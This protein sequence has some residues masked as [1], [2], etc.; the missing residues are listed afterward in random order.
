MMI[1]RFRWKSDI[2]RQI[3]DSLG[4]ENVPPG[5]RYGHF[6]LYCHGLGL[7]DLLFSRK[8]LEMIPSPQKLRTYSGYDFSY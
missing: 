7:F 4:T 5:A 6:E 2:R 3:A 8:S 1:R